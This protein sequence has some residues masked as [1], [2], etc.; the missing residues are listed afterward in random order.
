VVVC[1]T[2]LL[3]GVVALTSAANPGFKVSLS[4]NG[5]NYARQVA[6]EFLQKRFST[7]KLPDQNGQ[8]S[9]PIIGGIDWTLTNIVMSGLQIP[10]SAI[11]IIP[12][13]GVQIKF[14][15]AQVHLTMDFH[16][17]QRNWP[18]IE[19]SGNLVIQGSGI[20]IGVATQVGASNGKPTIS[21]TSCTCSIDKLDV[22]E[23]GGPSWLYNFFLS[24]LN[25]VVKQ[26]AEKGISGAVT[27]LINN[28][29][30]QALQTIPFT[31]DFA[32]IAEID[33]SLISGPTFGS[34]YL[35]LNAKGEFYYLPNKTEAPFSAQPMPDLVSEQKLQ[36][37]LSELVP[38]S[39]SYVFRTS[40]KMTGV[41]KDKNLPDWAPIRLI[42]SS[43]AYIIPEM[44][45]KYPNMQMQAQFTTS[46]PPTAQASPQGILISGPAEIVVSVL[47][48]DADP[49]PVFGINIKLISSGKA[50]VSEGKVLGVLSYLNSSISTGFSNVGTINLSLLDSI[51][52]LLCENAIVPFFNYYLSHGII[53]PTIHGVSLVNPQIVYGEGYIGVATDVTYTFDD[54]FIV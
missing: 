46:S 19:G 40:G 47:P 12:G 21:V 3:L 29:A 34:N 23:H 51:I 14:A 5:L 50:T 39:A 42:T 1:L 13:S 48:P 9:A 7:I 11:G 41:L 38:N 31:E 27:S 26:I 49:V 2:V 45:K 35:T 10:Q 20:S 17:R 32:D 4:Q 54:G 44:A 18:H 24:V 30:N 16:F 25:E 6:L 43:W 36:V 53:I 37:M 22:K 8:A 28:A 52:K 33:Y 15:D